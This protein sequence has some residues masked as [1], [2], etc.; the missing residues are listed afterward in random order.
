MHSCARFDAA[1]GLVDAPAFVDRE[2]IL[3]AAL[4]AGVRLIFVQGIDTLQHFLAPQYHGDGQSRLR[5]PCNNA[6]LLMMMVTV[7]SSRC[8]RN[9]V[10]LKVDPQRESAICEAAREWVE[11][12]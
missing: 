2:G 11:A 4:P 6:L 8:T 9:V 1:V 7:L 5:I 12:N 3:C 10:E